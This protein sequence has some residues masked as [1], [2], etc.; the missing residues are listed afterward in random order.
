MLLAVF[1]TLV[2]LTI[3]T[4]A[5]ASFDFGSMEV[6]VV[7][8]IATIKAGLVMAFFMHM[9]F[10]KPFNVIVFL[11]LVCFCRVVCDLYAQR[12]PP[13]SKSIEPVVEDVVPAVVEVAP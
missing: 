2:V 11:E 3:A 6:A 9:A 7:M 5:Q 13:D 1:A 8:I 10:D 4:V 12:Q